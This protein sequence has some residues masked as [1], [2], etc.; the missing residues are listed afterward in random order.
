MGGSCIETN[1]KPVPNDCLLS[2]DQS[3]CQEVIDPLDLCKTENA[4]A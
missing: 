3:L 1:Q 4:C 2:T